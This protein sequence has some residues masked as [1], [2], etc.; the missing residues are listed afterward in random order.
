MH[1]YHTVYAVH[2][3]QLFNTITCQNLDFFTCSI[4]K[5]VITILT[6]GFLFHCTDNFL[7]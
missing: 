7:D 5:N 4:A 3:I 2:F 1:T 6:F